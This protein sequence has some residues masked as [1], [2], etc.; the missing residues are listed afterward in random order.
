MTLFY[1]CGIALHTLCGARVEELAFGREV[2]FPRIAILL[3]QS[4]EVGIVAQAVEVR[5]FVD[6]VEIGVLSALQRALQIGECLLLVAAKCVD[7]GRIVSLFVVALAMMESMRAV[8]ALG[9]PRK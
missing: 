6:V 8:A 9:C 2:R 3:D 5:V 4:L 1:C 7:A